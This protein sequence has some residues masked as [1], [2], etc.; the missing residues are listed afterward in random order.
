MMTPTSVNH[1]S[2]SSSD[3]RFD[4]NDD[5]NDENDEEEEDEMMDDGMMMMDDM[6]DQYSPVSPASASHSGLMMMLG[7]HMG[8]G[9][10]VGVGGGHSG[11]HTMVGGIHHLGDKRPPRKKNWL[12]GDPSCVVCHRKGSDGVSFQRNYTTGSILEVY[13]LCF[14]DHSIEDGILCASCYAK[15]YAYRKK[16]NM[17][18][19][20]L[21]NKKLKEGQ[22]MMGVCAATAGVNGTSMIGSAPS[23]PISTGSI[24]FG[25]PST[26][27]PGNGMVVAGPDGTVM[28]LSGD[29]PS[30]VK[31]EEKTSNISTC[32]CCSK[33]GKHTYK[34][35]SYAAD[36]QKL[37]PDVTEISED[38]MVCHGCYRKCFK[39]RQSKMENGN[40]TISPCNTPTTLSPRTPF[41]AVPLAMSANTTTSIAHHFEH[42]S[43]ASTVLIDSSRS[44]F[45]GNDKDFVPPSHSVSTTPVTPTAASVVVFAGSS[46]EREA[47][48][49]VSTPS[50]PLPMDGATERRVSG[51]VGNNVELNNNPDDAVS[52]TKASSNSSVDSDPAKAGEKCVLCKLRLHP[53]FNYLYAS[54][55]DEYKAM[56]PD[57]KNDSNSGHVCPACYRKLRN[58]KK[59]NGMLKTSDSAS[60]KRRTSGTPDAQNLSDEEPQSKRSRRS[61]GQSST[62]QQQ[63]APRNG[64]S[65]LALFEIR[66]K[67]L[68]NNNTS[69]QTDL[70]TSFRQ[71]VDSQSTHS[72]LLR[73]AEEI[74]NK[75]CD[76]NMISE[77]KRISHLT[78]V[79]QDKWGRELHVGFLE[80]DCF[81]EFP[82]EP[83]TRFAIYLL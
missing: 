21:H 11:I 59:R 16:N 52:M 69:E 25:H 42:P 41:S 47:T 23:T 22:L 29:S 17:N 72:E 6:E 2:N 54:N 68:S 74:L 58:F 80:D 55:A 12:K 15:C 49:N 35:S 77:S 19:K 60:K 4:E 1:N 45:G 82:I 62:G 81:D 28:M 34:Y 39:M 65:V 56:C 63:Q 61:S 13:R 71:S 33:Q 40:E 76:Q 3:S 73:V 10:A 66:D 8:A 32:V 26:A 14:G 75:F 5:E 53:Q 83:K 36:Y 20:K 57:V 67:S 70:V 37:Y 48:N 9:S 44:S 64:E 7:S 18:I 50:T 38:S 24:G 27:S 79:E 46:S 30:I 43:S 51:N 31:S 78:M